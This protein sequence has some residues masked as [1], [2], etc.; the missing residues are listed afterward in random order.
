MMLAIAPAAGGHTLLPASARRQKRGRDRQTENDQHQDG[1]NFRQAL[2]EASKRI[3]GKPKIHPLQA[4]PERFRIRVAMETCG[5]FPI[6]A[7]PLPDKCEAIVTV[8]LQ[9]DAVA[10]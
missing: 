10:T 9:T 7:A 3:S 8:A 2:I 4:G 5:V 6:N 1:K